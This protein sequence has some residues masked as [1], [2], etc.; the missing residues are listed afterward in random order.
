MRNEL[1]VNGFS[2]VSEKEIMDVDGGFNLSYGFTSLGYA[3]GTITVV[4][5]AG[6]IAAIGG[7][8]VAG[9]VITGFAITTLCYA[10]MAIK[11]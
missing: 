7:P 3:A 6:T 2:A 9:I 4:K 10:Y 11:K 8:I 1:C 5:Y